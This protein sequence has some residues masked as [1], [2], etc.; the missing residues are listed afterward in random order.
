MPPCIRNEHRIGRPW[1]FPLCVHV[2]ILCQALRI[3]YVLISYIVLFFTHN[4]CPQHNKNGIYNIIARVLYNSSK[5]RT[6]K[7]YTIYSVQFGSS[8]LAA[9]IKYSCYNIIYAILIT[10]RT[11]IVSIYILYIYTYSE[12]VV[13]K[14]SHALCTAC[15]CVLHKLKPG[16]PCRTH[17][18]DISLLV[19]HLP[20]CTLSSWQCS[21]TFNIM[22]IVVPCLI[23]S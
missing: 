5:K 13:H 2:F 22:V 1:L 8:F 21:K 4:E 9:V 16:V 7:L 19:Y 14:P 10:L 11:F 17:I 20:T 15:A 3:I 12:Q 23:V 18:Y 6:A